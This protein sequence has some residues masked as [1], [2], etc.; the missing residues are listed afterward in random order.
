MPLSADE[1]AGFCRR[2]LEV[3]PVSGPA[4]LALD[5]IDV[6]CAG[7]SGVWSVVVGILVGVGRYCGAEVVN[8]RP[9][10]LPEIEGGTNAK[11]DCEG[12]AVVVEKLGE[13][14]GVAQL[15]LRYDCPDVVSKLDWVAFGY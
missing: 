14:C 1:E 5:S 2:S 15:S 7:K 13:N 12:P 10:M 11:V 9:C 3:L 8:G 4:S 6:R